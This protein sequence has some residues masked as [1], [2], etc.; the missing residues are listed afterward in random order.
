[1]LNDE[2]KEGQ[3]SKK[4]FMSGLGLGQWGKKWAKHTNN[5]SVNIRRKE[6]NSEQKEIW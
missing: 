1:M 4:R 3:N 6:K 5:E 2:L